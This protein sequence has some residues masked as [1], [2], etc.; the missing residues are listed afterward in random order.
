MKY[1]NKS[2]IANIQSLWLNITQSCNNKCEYCY[3]AGN[4]NFNMRP[5][6]FLKITELIRP[7]KIK[8]LIL[9]GGEPTLHPNFIDFAN[10]CSDIA[11]RVTLITNGTRLADPDFC[12]QIEMSPIS[13][14]LFSL[15]GHDENSHDMGTAREGSFR[16]ILEGIKNVRNLNRKINILPITTITSKNKAFLT[17]TLDFSKS[18]GFR[19][20]VYNI[21]VPSLASLK[22][23]LCVDPAEVAGLI[24]H[25]FL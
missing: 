15:L 10:K 8:T 24:E 13:T 4:D 21:C 23:D 1:E 14:I 22:G 25:L 19:K 20:A 12:R 18:L 6:T 11:E 2:Y 17:K 7:L 5:D 9:I 3:D 16:Q